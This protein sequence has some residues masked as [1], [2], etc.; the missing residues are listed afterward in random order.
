M[1]FAPKL[2]DGELLTLAMIQ[3][4]QGFAEEARW[5]V[6]P[7]PISGTCSRICPGK[8]AATPLEPAEVSFYAASGDASPTERHPAP[9]GSAG[10]PA[11]E[12]AARRIT[13]TRLPDAPCGDGRARHRVAAGHGGYP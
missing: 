2:S 10:L 7:G 5:L 13:R 1:G 8:P 4:L 11:I 6:M 12:D 9:F 3:M